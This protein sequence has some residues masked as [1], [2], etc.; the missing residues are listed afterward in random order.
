MVR[1][2]WEWLPAVAALALVSVQRASAEPLPPSVAACATQPD[3]SRRLACYDRE[4]AGLTHRQASRAAQSPT[5][6]ASQVDS[7]AGASAQPRPDS[8][9]LDDA[10]A[11]D[12]FGAN[13]EVL[14]KRSKDS[15]AQPSPLRRMTARVATIARRPG[16]WVVL[17]L[18]NNQV[19]EQSDDAPDLGL[20]V[21]ETVTIDKGILGAYWLTVQSHHAAI[22]VRRTR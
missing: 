21:G 11:Q 5:D 18:D 13:G 3:D 9:A 6:T 15:G 20:Q 16:G 19:W 1:L 2:P 10:S 17:H 7:N 4:V 12:E 8:R 22:K 14:R